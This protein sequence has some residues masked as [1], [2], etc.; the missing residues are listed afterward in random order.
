MYRDDVIAVVDGQSLKVIKVVP[1][2]GTPLDEF[3]DVSGDSIADI[4]IATE[5]SELYCLNSAFKVE[6]TSPQQGDSLGS[7]T[8]L[9]EWS[10]SNP[11]TEVQ[12]YVGGNFYRRLTKGESSTEI[13]LGGGER[14]IT[15]T[16]IG[17]YGD[18]SSDSVTVTVPKRGFSN[19]L[20]AAAIA[21][22]IGYMVFKRMF[23][24]KLLKRRRKRSRTL[25]ESLK[26]R[27]AAEI[28]EEGMAEIDSQGPPPP[29]PPPPQ[30]LAPIQ[31]ETG[32][33]RPPSGPTGPGG[34]AA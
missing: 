28:A 3:T 8:V 9:V 24:P 23:L 14:T 34:D 7:D 15:V 33:T 11:E 29:P 1:L 18:I 32:G 13:I 16:A 12:I 17:E 22:V 6:I 4:I 5:S 10:L 26:E 25:F 19:T 30:E 21:G 27:S 31:S 20:H 2:R